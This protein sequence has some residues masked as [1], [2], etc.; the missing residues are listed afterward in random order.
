MNTP[1]PANIYLT[2]CSYHVMYALQSESTLS[3][4]LRTKWLWVRIQL[5]SS[6]NYLFKKIIKTLKK[7]VNISE[8][9]ITIKT[10]F[11]SVHEQVNVIW[12][13]CYCEHFLL[14]TQTSQ[15]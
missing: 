8:V 15:N 7:D 11:Y 6:N 2:V 10:P 1:L 3:F 4:R 9:I 12:A 14:S 5:Q 13:E